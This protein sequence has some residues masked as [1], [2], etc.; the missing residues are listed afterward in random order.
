MGNKRSLVTGGGQGI[1]RAICEMLLSLGHEVIFVDINDEKAAQFLRESNSSA[2]RYV[3]CDV[4]DPD[5]ITKACG[6]IKHTYGEVSVLVNNAGIQTHVPFL[7]MSAACWKQ[8]L[9]INLN[10]A[11]YFC[12]EF[13]PAMVEQGWGRIV[14]I[15]S[16][17]A[18]RGS[19]RHVHYCTSKAGLVGMTRAL[20]LELAR[21]GVTVNAVCPGIVDTDI[22]QQTLAQK[23]EIWLNEMHVKRLGQPTDIANAVKFLVSEASDWISGQALD[24]NG[25]ILTP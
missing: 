10:A 19:N 18:R 3:R 16:M 23:R 25:G 2:L 24:V 1:G 21:Y 17:S 6:E 22:V 8:T 14:N 15:A 20:S 7:E 5:A 4:A 13:A 11:F 12:K 9:D